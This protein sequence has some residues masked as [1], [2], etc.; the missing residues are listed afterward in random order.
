[1]AADEENINEE[2]QEL[3]VEYQVLTKRIK[4]L[5]KQNEYFQSQL[6]DMNYSFEAL[7][8]F[9]KVKAGTEILVP[10][11]QGMYLK[12][13]LSDTKEFLVNVGA[14][15][16]VPKS[17]DDTRTMIKDQMMQ[18]QKYHYHILNE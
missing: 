14:H 2:M 8:E 1:M 15:V 3:Y 16:T 4:E 6:V 7:N 10:L 9:E 5:E 18:V 17:L 11:N 12:A 13:K